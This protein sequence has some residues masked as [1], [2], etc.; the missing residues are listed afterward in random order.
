MFTSLGK[1]PRL[2]AWAAWVRDRLEGLSADGTPVRMVGLMGQMHYVAPPG[3]SSAWSSR[4][5][6][7]TKMD[8]LLA[9]TA[10]GTLT[11]GDA[12]LLLALDE[13]T[14]WVWPRR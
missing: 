14:P 11:W 5:E 7:D 13:T 4:V 2:R 9:W 3:T 10:T 12:E 8:R 1:Q 6:G